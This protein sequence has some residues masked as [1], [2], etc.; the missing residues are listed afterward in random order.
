MDKRKKLVDLLRVQAV[1]PK[2]HTSKHL[3]IVTLPSPIQKR[4]FTDYQYGLDIDEKVIKM[5]CNLAERMAISMVRESMLMDTS[6]IV[7]KISETL[8]EKIIAALPEQ[9]TIIQQVVSD[10]VGMLKKE[11]GDL[12]FEGANIAIDRSKGLK[13]HGDIGEKTKS[14]DSTDDALA[15]L[16]NLI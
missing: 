5:A 10:E 1:R 6:K 15:A 12:V 8:V 14:K 7:E 9:Q 3:Q 2:K 4:D 16:D 11:M 13:L